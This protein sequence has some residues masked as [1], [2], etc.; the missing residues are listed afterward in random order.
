MNKQYIFYKQGKLPYYSM[1]LPP[2]SRFLH[3]YNSHI[4]IFY[5]TAHLSKLNK[6]LP[7][8]VTQISNLFINQTEPFIDPVESA[9]PQHDFYIPYSP[10]HIKHGFVKINHLSIQLKCSLCVQGSTT[11]FYWSMISVQQ[12]QQCYFSSRSIFVLTKSSISSLSY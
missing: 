12:K 7:Q 2:Q 9:V 8:Q 6:N 4:F 3:S 1:H 10:L 11:N 5:E